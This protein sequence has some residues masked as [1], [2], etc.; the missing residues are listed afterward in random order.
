M[1]EK[2]EKPGFNRAFLVAI[3][4]LFITVLHYS[5]PTSNPV[6]HEVYNRL[7]YIPIILG[8]FFY[9][10]GGG[11]TISVLVSLIFVP[12]IF[13]DWGGFVASNINMVTEVVLYNAVGAITGL[14]VS[15][16]R[17]YREKVGRDRGEAAGLSK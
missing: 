5:T 14:L 2:R 8:A 1:P 4:I 9:G 15:T 6:Y 10:L 11:I 17:R 16:E 12:H 3:I 7:Y 13:L